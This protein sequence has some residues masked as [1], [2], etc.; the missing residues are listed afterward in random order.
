MTRGR[1]PAV[2]VLVELAV[3]AGFLDLLDVG[4]YMGWLP[5]ADLGNLYFYISG[6]NWL[7]ALLSLIL[8]VVWFVI[9]KWLYDLNPEGWRLA[10]LIAMLNLALLLL[11]WLGQSSWRAVWLGVMANI[12]ALNLALLPD[13]RAAYGQS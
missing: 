5:M 13:T 3:I 12:I 2:W 7:G 1:N 6:A 9:A 4:R 10:I 8:G 11:A